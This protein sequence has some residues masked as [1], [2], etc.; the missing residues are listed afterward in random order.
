[1]GFD[2]VTLNVDDGFRSATRAFLLTVT[3]VGAISLA[4]IGTQNTLR[5]SVARV[6]LDITSP[7]TSVTNLILDWSSTNKTLVSKISFAYNGSNMVAIISLFPSR[8]GVD[9]IGITASDGFSRATQFFGLHTDEPGQMAPKL[10]ID[11]NHGGLAL[12]LQGTPGAGDAV[13][14]SIDLRHWT[15]AGSVTNDASGNARFVPPPAAS[16]L[17]LF[18]RAVSQ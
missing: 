12:I 8:G 13:Q 2:L 7:S 11:P 16:E 15:T 9:Y 4:P 1:V 10:T 17:I 5:G 6:S 3:P 14:S 18:F